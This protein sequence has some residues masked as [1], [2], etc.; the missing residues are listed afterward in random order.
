MIFGDSFVVGREIPSDKTVN[1]DLE[2]ILISDKIP[3][4]VINAG[5]QGYSTD[6]V[7][8]A[9]EKF[10]PAYKPDIVM[11]GL[12]SN[13]FG[14]NML[15][16]SYGIPKPVF[17]LKNDNHL[18]A[19]FPVFQ[20]NRS[21]G[22]EKKPQSWL[23][24]SALYRL[25]QPQIFYIRAKFMKWDEW[26]TVGFCDDFYYDPEAVKKI[27]KKLFVAM[28]QKMK[29]ISEDNE[30]NIVFYLQPHLGE[31]WEPHIKFIEKKFRLKS[32]QYDRYALQKF[33]SKIAEKSSMPFC[34]M[35]DFF[36]AH[37]SRGPFHML[38]RDQHPNA[39]GYEMV[40]EALAKFLS[41]E[42]LLKR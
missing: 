31:V 41:D 27:D 15:E 29:K 5:V 14:G 2:R 24:Y 8:L 33:L 16:E 34:S 11:Y 17:S 26:N 35:I 1:A 9:M 36:V 28:L 38:P 6:Q 21:I 39:A 25:L 32:G 40:S 7:L 18:E 4:E 30:A 23:Q 20:N 10:V 13:D 12:C 22:I 3:A 19:H 37:Q 42:G